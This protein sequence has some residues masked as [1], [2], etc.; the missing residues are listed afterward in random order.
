MI[1][2][3]LACGPGNVDSG[4]AVV[5]W[6]DVGPSAA[7]TAGFSLTVP[8]REGPIPARAWYPAAT[9]GDLPLEDL[10]SDPDDR[11]TLAALLAAAPVGCPSRTSPV[12]PEIATTGES[13]M[14]LLVYSHCHTCLGLSGATIAAHLA[15][16]GFVVVAPDHAGNTLFD[17]LDGDGGSLDEATLAQ[18]AADVSAVIDAALVDD[19]VHEGIRVDPD[20]IGV[21]GHSFGAVTVG[22]VLVTDPRVRAAMAMGAPFDNPLLQ[23]VDAAAVTEPVLLLELEEDHSVGALGNTLIEANYD[24]L[25]GP[26]WLARMPDAGHWS[27]SDLCG[28]VDDL[29]PGCGDDTRQ[30]DLT[31]FTYVPAAEARASAAS[32]AAAFFSATL[33]GDGSAEAWLLDPDT[34]TDVSVEAR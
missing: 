10:V 22:R 12:S 34:T 19:F 8:G 16:H 25:A 30:A 17:A 28:V 14:P 15:S 6:S 4:E 27:V 3:L 20:R 21:I 7:G 9:L 18:R 32:V 11:D 2:A 33:L 31:P 23:G 5:P 29:M 26:A 1:L 24:E 13:A